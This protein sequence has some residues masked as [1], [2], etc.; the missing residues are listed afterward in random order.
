[1]TKSSPGHQTKRT[2]EK[3]LVV[4]GAEFF[5]LFVMLGKE[6]IMNFT[7]FLHGP[8]FNRRINERIEGTPQI[9]DL[10]MHN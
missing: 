4:F 9:A 5:C 8:T 10:D 2:E 3:G 6:F 1:M 7:P